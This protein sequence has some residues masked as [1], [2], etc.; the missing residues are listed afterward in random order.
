[1]NKAY[2]QLNLEHAPFA[3]LDVETTGL[4]PERGHRICEIAIVRTVGRVETRRFS[5]LVNPGRRIG[6]GAQAVNGITD[7]MVA[8]A[9]RF[10]ELLEE[11]LPMLDGAVVVAHNAPFDLGFVNHELRLAWQAPLR[12][13]VVDTLT[14]A[15]RAYRFPSNSLEALTHRLGLPHPQQHRALGDVLAVQ[16]LLWWLADDLQS[17]GVQTLGDLL[18]IQYG[19]HPGSV[20]VEQVSPELKEAIQ[21]G[22]PI[23]LRYQ[24]RQGHISERRVDP[25][26][27]DVRWG[28]HYLIAY[29]HLQQAERSFRLDRIL[30]M[31][32]EDVE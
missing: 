4:K 14:I 26:R 2:H 8:D 21:H 6:A 12:N 15:R 3:F 29:C 32:I 18:A 5:S 19:R 17:K 27:I 16:N 24:S 9:P 23:Q 22:R 30:E 7:S 10:H 13:P 1:M 11:V 20:V 28:M 31:R 25:I